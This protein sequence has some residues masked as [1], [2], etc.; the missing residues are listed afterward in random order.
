MNDILKRLTG[1]K[2]ELRKPFPT[3]D[4]KKIGKISEQNF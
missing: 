2:V 3:E 4:I 1:M